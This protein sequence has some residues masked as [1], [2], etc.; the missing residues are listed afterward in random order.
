M[1]IDYCI[2][3]IEIQIEGNNTRAMYATRITRFPLIQSIFSR[4]DTSLNI[5]LISKLMIELI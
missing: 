4:F 1:N 2:Q 5:V 3:K